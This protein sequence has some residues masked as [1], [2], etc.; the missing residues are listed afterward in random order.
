MTT[1]ERG[2]GLATLAPDDAF[3]LLG[4]ETRMEMLQTLGDT[5][6]PMS[7]TELFDRVGVSDSGQF[8]YHLDR[9]AGHFVRSSDDGYELQRAGERVVE[10][11]LSGAVTES[12]EME[13]TQTDMPCPLCDGPVEVSYRDEWVAHSCTECAGV[14]GGS[15][16][17]EANIPDEM[18]DSGYLGGFS[19]P[20]AG[21][22]GREATDVLQAA[23]VW[24]TLEALATAEGICPRCSA[25]LQS[26]VDVCGRHDA[27]NG[28]CEQCGFQW[29]VA[30]EVTCANC[31]YTVY[32]PF[33]ISLGTNTELIAFG[34]AHGYNPL[35]PTDVTAAMDV[36]HEV[37][38]TDPFEARFT[39]SVDGDSI[40]LTVDDSL[41]VIEI[42]QT[43]SSSPD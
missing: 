18:I 14:Y 38:S 3:A 22:Q 31:P 15:P 11:V 13:P 7:F 19:L 43:N 35:A 32:G 28:L 37:L 36:D 27:G 33:H 29:K 25:S 21:L 1:D 20:P 6:E 24:G 5:D 8:N 4:N 30:I 39:Y 41:E 2:S 9:L 26:S 16:I 34:S 23:E 17:N 40:T 42:A 12:P 10:A